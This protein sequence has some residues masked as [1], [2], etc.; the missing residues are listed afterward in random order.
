MSDVV[1]EVQ[2]EHV[3]LL[4]VRPVEARQ[5]LHRLD[6]GERLVHVHRV[7]QRL[8]V[9]G[10]ELVRADQE[11]GTDPPGILSAILFDGKPFSLGLADLRPAVLMLPGEGHDG[12]VGALSLL[13]VVADGME[14]LD[15]PLD[16]V[17]DDHR[18]R[19]A[20]D[21]AMGQDLVVE[22]VHHDLGLEAD[23]VVVALDEAPQ[24]LPGL[25]DV[26]LRVVLHRLGELVVALDRR[27]VRQHV[28]DETLLDRLL[29]AVGVERRGAG[30]FAVGLCG[31]RLAEDL[32]RLVLGRRGEGEV[33]GVGQQLARLHQ[34]VDPI[35][36]GLLVLTFYAGLG[37]CPRH[38]GGWSARPG[39]SEPRR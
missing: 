20:A 29:H 34:A 38:G 4:G 21:L 12:L 39:W 15:G 14:V 37:Q 11:S 9:A 36:E 32:Q 17:G 13:Q 7:Q 8:V 19:S 22:V 2:H 30:P 23:R 26:E 27:V 31:V 1:Q 10:L 3:V 35:L 6:A 25:L 28:Q 18:P 5:R 33:A 24:L 16:P